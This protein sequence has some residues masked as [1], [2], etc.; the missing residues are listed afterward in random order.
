MRHL[1]TLLT[2]IVIAAAPP[3]AAWASTSTIALEDSAGVTPPTPVAPEVTHGFCFRP[4]PLPK[5]K[6]YFIYDLGVS[7]ELGEEEPHDSEALSLELGY[8]RNLTTKDA[9]GFGVIGMATSEANKLAVRARYRRWLSRTVGLDAAAGL[10]VAGGDEQGSSPVFPGVIGSL[11]VQVG[12]VV[13]VTLEAE[14]ARYQ[15]FTYNYY[16]GTSTGPESR[17][18]TQVRVRGQLGS[19]FGVAGTV[20]LLIVGIA[21]A[22]SWES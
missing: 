22:A 8:M 1:A 2:A 13:G 17:S 4:Q 18:D 12:G 3:G 7:F 19:G 9:V 15:S 10:T 6:A 14:Q 5:C 21:I 11:G 20:F 16:L